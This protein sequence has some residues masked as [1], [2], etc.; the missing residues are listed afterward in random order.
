M[1]RRSHFK[2]TYHT[3][4]DEKHPAQRELYDVS[5]DPGELKNLAA[6]PAY[7]DKVAELHAALLKELRENPDATEQRCRADA[8]KAQKMRR[9]KKARGTT[10]QED[11]GEGYE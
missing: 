4:P 11:G 5:C 7:A 9:G 2:Y 6:D 8:A 3:P 1:I 10:K